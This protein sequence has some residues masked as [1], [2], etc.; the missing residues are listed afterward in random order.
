MVKI[1]KKYED[2][3][4]AY[5]EKLD[6][7]AEECS[8]NPNESLSDQKE[9]IKM[10][11]GDL[12]KFARY[13][14]PK[15]CKGDA[16]PF[17]VNLANELSTRK[18]CLLVKMWSRALAKTTYAA[19]II[20]IFLMLNDKLKFMVLASANGEGAANLLDNIKAQLE[21]NPRLL[22]DFGVFK[23][24]GNW[25]FGD[26]M[27][28]KGVIFKSFGRREKPRGL[29]VKGQRPDFILCDDLDDDELVKNPKLVKKAYEWMIRALFGTFSIGTGRFVIVGNLISKTSILKLVSE[30]KIAEVE[31]INL[32]DENGNPAWDIYT[33]EDCDYMIDAMTYRFA[34][35]EYFNNPIEEGTIFKKEY[36]QYKKCL[37][38]K[39]YDS[40]ICYTDPSFTSTGDYKAT[41]LIGKKREEYHLLKA[42]VEQT[43]IATMIDWH[44][45]MMAYVNGQANVLYYMEA[46]F[47]Q[48]TLIDNFKKAAK[49]RK[50]G[51]PLRP[52]KRKKPEKFGR[53][54]AL[55]PY[56][57][58][59]YFFIDKKELGNKHIDTLIEQFTNM[60]KGTRTADDG[61]DAVEG[62]I[63]LLN[64]RTETKDNTIIIPHKKSHS[65]YRY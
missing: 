21:A 55:S 33:K 57:E 39:N 5:Q 27:T 13:Y 46:N 16:A 6:A 15:L 47:L 8:V 63:F 29:N 7:A 43:S 22:H 25:E 17:H 51:V 32:L 11:L 9:R 53:I 1:K 65:K 30:N 56:F 58:N 41:V 37:N 3:L 54:E 31:Q 4:K 2:Q 26:F 49:K 40:I 48:G 18:R 12:N 24:I 52:D 36:F 14:F 34:Q 64:K 42:F 62:A 10:L 28:R 19:M 59:G 45:Q 35:A 38:L 60:E 50:L 44:Y 20:P 61:P 23:K